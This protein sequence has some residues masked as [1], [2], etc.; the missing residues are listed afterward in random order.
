MK[1][2][3][4]IKQFNQHSDKR[5]VLYFAEY[6][7]DIPFEIRRVYYICDV[8]DPSTTR[9]F[10]AHKNLKQVMVCLGGR[11]DVILDDGDVRKTVT[12]DTPG[13]AIIIEPCI[14]REM[15]NFSD[16]ASLVVFASE[17][18]DENDYIRDYKDILRYIG[19]DSA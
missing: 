5:G 13:K 19:K 18:Y 7:G 1:G 15:T 6:P 12:L 14:W 8:N 16:N 10:H 2:S 17:P 9:G 3:I 4:S 11:C